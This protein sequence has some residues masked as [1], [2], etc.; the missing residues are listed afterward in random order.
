MSGDRADG[1]A[2]A[3]GMPRGC[4]VLSWPLPHRL[5]RI[6]RTITRASKDGHVQFPA[7]RS[8]GLRGLGANLSVLTRGLKQT[9]MPNR[10]TLNSRRLRSWTAM[11]PSTM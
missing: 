6:Y 7:G 4:C 5:A 11:R 3:I 1:G 8:A 10:L 9:V 2:A